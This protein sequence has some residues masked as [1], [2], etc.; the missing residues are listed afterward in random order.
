[1][2]Q[3]SEGPSPPP[4]SVEDM[5]R[6]QRKALAALA[7]SSAISEG[8]VATA[9]AQLTEVAASVLGVERASVWRFDQEHSRIECVNLFERSKRRHSRGLVIERSAAPRYFAALDSERNISAANALTDARTSE[10]ADGYLAP[11]GIGAMLDA[12]VFEGAALVG[13]VCHEHVGAPRAWRLWEE[14]VAATMADLVAIALLTAERLAAGRAL[15]AHQRALERLV[16]ERTLK[17]QQTERDLG[18][19]FEASPVPLFLVRAADL[20]VLLSNQR[21]AELL[22]A[23][24]SLGAICARE[25]DAARLVDAAMGPAPHEPIKAE[26]VGTNGP[27]FAEL[28]VERITHDGDDA[29]LVG[30]H[31]VTRQRAAEAALLELAVRDG[32]TGVFNRRHFYSLAREECERAD[33][34]KRP[35]SFALLDVDHFKRINDEHG[36]ATGDS[37]LRILASRLLASM[38]KA[39]IVARFGGEEFVMMLPETNLSA[40]EQVTRRIHAAAHERSY[41]SPAGPRTFTVSIGVVERAPGEALEAAVE[42]ADRAMY[43]AKEAGRDRVVVA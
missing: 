28:A 14:L 8:D 42:R 4:S 41:E 10:F 27:L 31:D 23:A 17:L 39:D 34:Y 12:P 32:L 1:M 36:H 30:V 11:L 7:R 20:R 38:R 9:L 6:P 24:Q 40:A 16:E 15:A 2:S 5:L 22:G 25:G 18:R 33:R 29:L 13:V 35:V 37:V 19:L 43:A 26:L 21:A 3:D